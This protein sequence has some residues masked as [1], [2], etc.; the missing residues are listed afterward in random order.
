MK[1]KVTFE[2]DIPDLT[3]YDHIQAWLEYE[4]N[5][6]GLLKGDNKLINHR[7]EA[8]SFSVNFDEC[9]Y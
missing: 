5:A 9:D 2:L 3:P 7:L 1:I 8:D 4:L 6:N